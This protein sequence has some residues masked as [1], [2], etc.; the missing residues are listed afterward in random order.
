MSR[1]SSAAFFV[2][3]APVRAA[4]ARILGIS[5]TESAVSV[6]LLHLIVSFINNPFKSV[7]Q[8]EGQHSLKNKNTPVPKVK[9][10]YRGSTLICNS[11]AL[12]QRYG[13]GYHFLSPTRLPGALSRICP[14]HRLQ[15][16]RHLSGRQGICILPVHNLY[17]IILQTKPFVNSFCEFFS[18]FI[19]LLKNGAEYDK[20]S[21]DNSFS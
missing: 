14:Q 9:G 5:L 3:S 13:V 8:R 11:D 17:T 15:P 12:T 6:L 10:V 18:I 16:W 20:I 4:L 7:F 19:Y 21:V 2:F 1:M